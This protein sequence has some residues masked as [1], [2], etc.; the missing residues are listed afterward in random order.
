MS[1]LTVGQNTPMAR[2]CSP[3]RYPSASDRHVFRTDQSERCLLICT[4]GLVG[5]VGLDGAY[6]PAPS[7]AGICSPS[8]LATTINGQACGC[9]HCVHCIG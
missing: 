2:S 6:L 3:G 9:I 5:L 4:L 1:R 8:R 7:T